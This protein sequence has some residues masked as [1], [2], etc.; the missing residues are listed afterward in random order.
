MNNEVLNRRWQEVDMLLSSFYVNNSKINAMFRK[1]VQDVFEGIKYTYEDLFNW[2]DIRDIMKLRLE[3]NDIRDKY[4]LEGY[5]GYVLREM[6]KKEP[7]RNSEVLIGLLMV[8]YYRRYKEQDKEEKK[9]F[10]EIINLSYEQGQQE[11]IETLPKKKKD[12]VRLLTIPEAF[13]LQLWAM[14]SY[15][16]YAWNDYKEG[17][18]NYNVR[19]LFDVVKTNM[20]TEKVLDTTEY[21]IKK[22]LDKQDKSYL[23]KKKDIPRLDEQYVDNYSG[24]LDNIISFVTNQ[25]ALK[26]MKD[27][28]V[29]E[30]Q[31][32]A[33]LD[34]KTT[35]MCASLDGQIFKINGWNTY[36][37]YSK[38]DDSN[39]IYTTYG[40]EV[41]A[42]LPPIDNGFHYCR[43]TIYP[44]R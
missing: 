13:T 25:V 30:V 43:S 17:T 24:A 9:M 40:L 39:I 2:A 29:E 11:A 38:E 18:I 21:N 7:M 15:R 19:Q 1:R 23:N 32:I 35:D 27:Q 34:E 14:N 33:V 22:I 31:F 4:G 16:G 6:V 28:G 37:R 41:G 5:T 3:I 12:R 36:S 8:E 20:Q 10:D 44:Y 42:N 26:G